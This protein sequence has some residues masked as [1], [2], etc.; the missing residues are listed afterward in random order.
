M[1]LIHFF[2]KRKIFNVYLKLCWLLLALILLSYLIFICLHIMFWCGS[3]NSW[4]YCYTELLCKLN[5]LYI[6]R[7]YMLF[8][9]WLQVGLFCIW[10]YHC[11]GFWIWY[12]FSLIFWNSYFRVF[13]L[14]ENLSRKPINQWIKSTENNQNCL[15]FWVNFVN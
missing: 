5:D 10:L 8:H 14:N 4:F 9:R 2:P 7:R 6:K 12:L 3:E 11:V 1:S 13:I 15:W